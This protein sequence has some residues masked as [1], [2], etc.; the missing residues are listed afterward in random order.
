MCA[1]RCVALRAVTP[2]ARLL[3]YVDE[4]IS[5]SMFVDF[6]FSLNVK[7]SVRPRHATNISMPKQCLSISSSIVVVV[8][9]VVVVVL[10]IEPRFEW[11]ANSEHQFYSFLC[12][13]DCC[14]ARHSC[15]FHLISLI[16]NYLR[17]CTVP[18]LISCSQSRL[19]EYFPFLSLSLYI[20]VLRLCR[21]MPFDLSL[22]FDVYR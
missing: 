8:V 2:N 15:V 3:I 18:R 21:S 19:S 11:H 17:W 7:V 13:C 1:G 10:F 20:H 9:V 22:A 6:F 5:M 12:V 14:A 16:S 4:V